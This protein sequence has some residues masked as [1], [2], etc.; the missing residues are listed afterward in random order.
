MHP[1]PPTNADLLRLA[2]DVINSQGTGLLDVPCPDGL[3]PRRWIG[4][5]VHASAIPFELTTFIPAENS[6]CTLLAGTP[7]V[8]WTFRDET[9]HLTLT[10]RGPARLISGETWLHDHPLEHATGSP[11]PE[12]RPCNAL[13]TPVQTLIC[14]LTDAHLRCHVVLPPLPVRPATTALLK[15]GELGLA[16]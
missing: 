5:S 16:N 1:Q 12:Q 14:T 2:V 7:M 8:E 3:P 10:L 6:L 13:I 11:D 15:L 4:A 9:R